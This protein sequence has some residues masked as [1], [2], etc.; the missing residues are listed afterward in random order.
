MDL[1]NHRETRW[2]PNTDEERAAVLHHLDL[3]LSNPHFRNSK[4]YKAFLDYVVRQTLT[5]KGDPLKERTL[6]VEIFSRPP[7]YDTNLDPIVR[8]TAGEIRKRL[9]QTYREEEPVDIRIDLPIG[10]YVPLIRLIDQS[11][12][13]QAQPSTSEILAEPEIA[14]VGDITTPATSLPE[15]E[16]RAAN[17]GP[18]P[19]PIFFGRRWLWVWAAVC[20]AS[21]LIAVA[22][23]RWLKG[24]EPIA[25][26]WHPIMSLQSPVMIVI[27]QPRTSF[28]DPAGEDNVFF[29]QHQG[30]NEMFFSG[31]IALSRIANLLGSHPYEVLPSR[32]TMLPSL[33]KR[34]IVLIGAF[35]NPW[36]LRLLKPL[37]FSFAIVGGGESGVSPQI[38]QILDSKNQAGSPWAVDFK[39]PVNLMSHDYAIIARFQDDTTDGPVMVVAGIGST[40]TESA[41]EFVTSPLYM[42]QFANL[43]PSRWSGINMEA[44]I[45]TEIIDG[46][47]GHPHIIAAEFW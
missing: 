10:S 41:G 47:P 23:W 17:L 44:V 24:R 3:L 21:L 5:G 8:V 12:L 6:G 45:E 43:A 31:G 15:G 4:R 11:A 39:Q 42:K 35:D 28:P 18:I 2:V 22:G 19:S 32:S 25:Q 9:A 33:R 26:M 40:G 29:R 30:A 1:E 38:L 20:I 7:D 34:P 27:G 16:D 13:K 46:H 14:D 36:T 37:R